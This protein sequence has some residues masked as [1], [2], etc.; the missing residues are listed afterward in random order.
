MN[1]LLYIF[2]GAGFGCIVYA[3]ARFYKKQAAPALDE[4]EQVTIEEQAGHLTIRY[5]KADFTGQCI[6]DVIGEDVDKTIAVHTI[7]L[8]LRSTVASLAH[9]RREDLYEIE[10]HLYMRY[11]EAEIVWQSP[12]RLLL[13]DS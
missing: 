6:Y 8:E 10:R 9:W 5:R 3:A 4:K 11:P 13:Q 1:V 2:I 12:M 7:T